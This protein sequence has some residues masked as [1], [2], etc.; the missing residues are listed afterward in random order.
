MKWI[1]QFWILWI[2][3]IH[4]FAQDPYYLGAGQP[5]QDR[6]IP[7]YQQQNLQNYQRQQPQST[8]RQ[9]N[10]PHEI[11]NIY[12]GALQDQDLRLP[13]RFP[14]N[15]L[16]NQPINSQPSPFRLQDPVDTFSPYLSKQNRPSNLIQP[17]IFNPNPPKPTPGFTQSTPRP[18][19]S[20]LHSH[21]PSQ[22]E[23]FLGQITIESP[24]NDYTNQ[25]KPAIDF[26]YP[27]H[28]FVDQF[29]SQNQQPKQTWR[30]QTHFN[31]P[32]QIN[33]FDTLSNNDFEGGRKKNTRI[34]TNNFIPQKSS[35]TEESQ[36]AYNKPEA[37]INTI[38]KPVHEDDIEQDI[39]PTQ[40][41]R[42][43]T[44]F[45]DAFLNENK[46]SDN[47]N[48]NYDYNSKIQ[49][50]L[51]DQ[52][53]SNNNN[54]NSDDVEI[55]KA[56]TTELHHDST[57]KPQ[58]ALLDEGSTE[59]EDE[60]T[61]YETAPDN[62]ALN[63]VNNHEEEHLESNTEIN[64]QSSTEQEAEETNHEEE[65][66]ESEET[67]TDAPQNETAITNDEPILLGE[68]VVSV[69][70]TKSVV[71]GTI[72]IPQP[73]TTP[74]PPTTEE[75]K[76]NPSSTTESWLYV[77]S[78]QTSRSVSGARFLPFD[79]QE[80]KIK[81]EVSTEK[82]AVTE[83]SGEEEVESTEVNKDKPS[84]TESIIDKLDRVQSELSSGLLINDFKNDNITVIQDQIH[85][86]NLT[87]TIAPVVNE[88][89][90]STSP[91]FIRKFSPYARP[92]TTQRP[93]KKSN[94]FDNI[95]M[96]DLT[97]LLPSGF[98]PRYQNNRRTT[99]TSTT[100]A[101]LN[102][103]GLQNDQP[104]PE[105]SS[106]RNYSSGR[107]FGKPTQNK[108]K[109]DNISAFLP[110]DY[111][112]KV[113][114]SDTLKV[115]D[116]I[117][118]FLPK[119]YS[120]EKPLIKPVDDISAFLPPGYKLTS[121]TESSKKATPIDFVSLLPPGY[122]LNLTKESVNI[123]QVRPVD[124]SAFLP[125]DYKISTTTSAP[126]TE[127]PILPKAIPV[128]ISAFLP[129]GFKLNKTS[130]D[131]KP[132]IPI[133]KSVDISA[134]LPPGYK[135]TTEKPVIE[136]KPVDISSFLPPGYKLPNKGSEEGSTT[137]STTTSA[138]TSTSTVHTGLNVKFPTKLGGRKPI[139]YRSS[140]QKPGGATGGPSNFTPT[141]RKGPPTRATT[142]FTGWPTPSTTPISIEKLLEAARTAT[143]NTSP[144]VTSSEP[145]TSTTTTTTTTTTTPRP[146]TPG[147]CV[148]ECDLAGTIKLVGG[149]KWV[150]ELLNHNTKEW[151]LL[152]N[153]VQT[154]LENAYSKSDVLNRW[155]KKIR[156]DGFSEGSVLV[157]YFV[158]LND[159]GRRVDTQEL[160]RLFHEALR[161]VP[162]DDMNMSDAENN[163]D[164]SEPLHLRSEMEG[165]LNL[166]SF[167]VDPNF[168]DFVVF[169]KQVAPTVGYADENEFLPQWAI[170]VIVIGLASL[171]F[172]IIFG[173]TVL[174]NR[175]KNA[176]KRQP[177]PLTED[178][179]NEL[180]KSHMGGIDNYGA[181]DLYNM[182]DVWND[183]PYDNMKLPKK[184]S[185]GSLQDN[186]MS[187]LYDSWRSEW[188]GY[189]YNAYYG[190]PSSSASLGAYGRRRS[191]YDTNF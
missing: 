119:D 115:V 38:S 173:V 92:S 26:K 79:I 83:H 170:A 162:L 168:T 107:S 184:R 43:S 150:P 2:L 147:I 19:Y 88:T 177:T 32:E 159:L 22:S 179:L 28:S 125:K 12:S 163:E 9:Q 55:V 27:S 118:K 58:E 67:E 129:P 122:K 157:D 189:Y 171:L 174:V 149:A 7:N 104:Q 35:F 135:L 108:I 73:S 60:N 13:H 49:P 59:N 148:G 106:R 39:K 74:V 128:D 180:N 151:Q 50:L 5:R 45:K 30:Q 82:P 144:S 90:P 77:A 99:S 44:K 127:K 102:D 78:V 190:N 18:Q 47:I 84:S 158:E 4:V 120:T 124:I 95:K 89:K 80:D 182:E 23:Q 17:A 145:T 62:L 164:K 56:I 181:E 52:V 33:S 21:D 66:E 141:I 123:P 169:P 42:G 29:S 70:T 69:V 46:N 11:S 51:E 87:T 146:T 14:S 140:T 116:D 3:I 94:V 20:H 25:F 72:S 16:Y 143:G 172:V 6:F 186:S 187:N 165:K 15:P 68:A 155:Y 138:P 8:Y 112:L 110:P 81:K 175:Q 61:T 34:K 131:E 111:K 178:M 98:K 1:G 85:E 109:E 24:N 48:N 100:E 142:E 113:N 166:G 101:N 64:E 156:I 132:S 134:F 105:I 139:N 176:K 63:S 114:V 152:A 183:R 91:V 185:A 96:D 37:N 126:K 86:D 10:F 103:E 161:P 167:I 191:D 97:G 154:Q 41:S 75:M 153:E 71:N 53:A 121:T 93:T 188:N 117:T 160:K 31:A 57:S 137:T 76:Q 130:G 36:F 65:V 40:F 54:Y 133:A 136:A